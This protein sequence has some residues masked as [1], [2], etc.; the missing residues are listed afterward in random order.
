[1]IYLVFLLWLIIQLK[2]ILFHA[3]LWQTKEYRWDRMRDFIHSPQGKRVVEQPLLYIKCGL[4]L[5]VMLAIGHFFSNFDFYWLEIFEGVLGAIYLAILLYETG[6]FCKELKNKSFKRPKRTK[7]AL[8]IMIVSLVL[9]LAGVS[10]WYQNTEYLLFYLLALVALDVAFPVLFGGIVF[11]FWPLTLFGKYYYMSK[12]AKKLKN[13][14]D[15]KIIGIT[16]SY[17]KSSTKEFL[18]TILESTYSVVKTPENWNS[19][20]GVAKAILQND[21]P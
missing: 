15:L 20:M 14:P 11:L 1:M 7:K 10:F 3:S 5:G 6:M 2:R 13:F 12:A 9:L 18:A 4:V 19:E 16:G 17:G 8:L 21:F